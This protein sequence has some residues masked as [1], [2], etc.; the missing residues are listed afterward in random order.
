MTIEFTE[1]WAMIHLPK[2]KSKAIVCPKQGHLYPVA[3]RQIE[4]LSIEVCHNHNQGNVSSTLWHCKLGHIHIQALRECQKQNSV[5]GLPTVSFETIKVCEGCLYRKIS[6][7]SFSPSSTNITK[8]LQL[9]H[10]DLCGPF[11]IPSMSGAKYFITFIDNTTRFTVVSFVKQKAQAFSAFSAFKSLA[12]NQTNHKIKV[13][14]SDNGGEF[15]SEEWETFCQQHGILHQKSVPYTMQWQQRAICKI[16]LLTAP[17]K[18]RYHLHYGMAN[19][20]MYHISKSL[21]Q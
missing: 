20:L 4:A 16:E 17:Y 5:R 21:V 9:V 13:K 15:T 12:E 7:K 8:P 11:S 2:G 10:S 3:A 18:E 6:H 1:K 14:H 19:L